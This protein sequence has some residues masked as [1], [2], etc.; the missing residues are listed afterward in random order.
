MY[1]IS[2]KQRK[3]LGFIFLYVSLYCIF[4]SLITLFFKYLTENNTG[5]SIRNVKINRSNSNMFNLPFNCV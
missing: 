5:A 3:K 2:S 4:T 1:M